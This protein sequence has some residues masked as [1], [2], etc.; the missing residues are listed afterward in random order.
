MESDRSYA[1]LREVALPGRRTFKKLTPRYPLWFCERLDVAFVQAF[2]A[3]AATANS[4]RYHN[5]ERFLRWVALGDN[6]ATRKLF[7]AFCEPDIGVDEQAFREAIVVY[8]RKLANLND[9][10]L[11]PG[12]L[13][14]RRNY[15]QLLLATIRSL[16]H[17]GLLPEPGKVRLH[18]LTKGEH[19]RSL[20]EMVSTGDRLSETNPSVI[21]DLN[22]QRLAALR[23]ASSD[24]LLRAAEMLR[25]GRELAQAHTGV[26]PEGDNELSVRVEELADAA[27]SP[28]THESAHGRALIGLLSAYA[29][30]RTDGR[31]RPHAVSRLRSSLTA[32][33]GVD[34]LRQY[35]TPSVDALLAAQLVVLID[36]GLNVAVLE[37]LPANPFEA[38]VVSG[39]RRL[40]R[41]SGVKLRA[42]GTVAEAS[43]ADRDDDEHLM[44]KDPRWAVSAVK[45]IEIWQEMTRLHR[46]QAEAMEDRRSGQLWLLPKPGSSGFFTP[47][48]LGVLISGALE[49]QRGRLSSDP[50]LGE[51]RF[52]RRNIRPSFLQDRAASK[53]WSAATAALFANHAGDESTAPYLSRGWIKRAY[54]EMIRQFQEALQAR[55]SE[56]FSPEQTP[57][58]RDTG[59]GFICR[60]P[61]EKLE[62]RREASCTEVEFC[63]GCARREFVPTQQS[64]RDLLRLN[65]S[66]RASEAA[67]LGRNPARWVEVWMRFLALTEALLGL[68]EQSRWRFHLARLREEQE[69]ALA[70]GSCVLIQPW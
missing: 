9:Q 48:T 67:F 10:S 58:G 65:A 15:I 8:A 35:I 47:R 63:A 68:L 44:V 40:R 2:Q 49:R 6:E 26:V 19:L 33:G 51:L 37:S 13:R 34:H 39:R 54:D 28:L 22:R 24:Y 20:G 45:V 3:T 55:L 18:R 42:H 62:A 70:E 61:T 7:A 57:N 36:T 17:S 5:L 53:N 1:T 31:L 29:W 38:E 32:F 66:L 60:P 14:T 27:A 30:K 56:D 41:I 64:I 43:L 12:T 59:L 16:S 25:I 69:Q 50:V 21:V 11:T 52:S 46:G 4:T 23:S